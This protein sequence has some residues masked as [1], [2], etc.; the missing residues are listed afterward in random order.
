MAFKMKGFSAH[1]GVKSPLNKVEEKVDIRDKRDKKRLEK[2]VE[3]GNQKR[4]DRIG[5]RM[6]KRANKRK[7]GKT[8]V[9]PTSIPVNDPSMKNYN[10][11]VD[12]RTKKVEKNEE[13]KPTPPKQEKKEEVKK[14]EQTFG[15]AFKEARKTM[16]AG[17]TFTY[18]G[19]KY[20]TNTAEDL[21]K[22]REVKGNAA[23]PR[24]PNPARKETKVP[25]KKKGY[26]K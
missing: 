19:K 23:G 26:K 6:S 15:Q 25:F 16:G 14:P 7:E 11:A 2:A 9:A 1:K 10:K 3:K 12:E 17:K 22:G 4:I 5:E 18:K 8:Q 13:V 24:K 21:K 20:T